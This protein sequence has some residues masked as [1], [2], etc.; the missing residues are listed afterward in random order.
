MTTE[1]IDPQSLRLHPLLKQMPVPPPE[2]L[3]S[4]TADIEE[5]GVDDP[6]IVDEKN[7]VMGGRIRLRIILNLNLPEVV[8]V[9]R[10][11]SE[12]ATIIVQ[13][14]LQ[15]RH[16]SK[17][18]LAYL[19]FPL[20]EPMLA[21]AR[22]RQLG[23]LRKGGSRSTQNVLL[24]KT[25][26]GIARNAGV[27]RALFFQAA[28]VHKL[29]A[30]YPKAKEHFEP[31]ILN[32]ELCLGYAIN[33]IAGL[34]STAGKPRNDTPQLELFARATDTL[35]FRFLKLTTHEARV[36]AAKKF[37]STV[38]DW[39]DEFRSE[40]ARQLKVVGRAEAVR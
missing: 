11:S 18:A 32:G 16:H 33:G 1:I 38:G 22:D 31:E 14:L 3:E 29:F 23:F 9:R 12:A 10:S 15:R 2:L 27:S 17:S 39:P 5:R 26:E 13:S 37:G 30:K 8:I 28:E 19:A 21:E 34:T 20:F 24:E 36:Q 6:L 25:A 35:V 40:I 7:R 4:M